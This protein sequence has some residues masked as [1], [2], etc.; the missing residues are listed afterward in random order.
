MK[1][2]ISCLIALALLSGCSKNDDDSPALSKGESKPAAESKTKS[3]PAAQAKS[4]SVWKSVRNADGETVLTLDVETQKRIGLQV[5]NPPVQTNLPEIR[6]SGRVLDPTPLAEG[7]AELE[8][9]RAALGASNLEFERLKALAAQNN[10]SARALQAAE[11][12][13]VRDRLAAGSARTK[14]TLAWGRELAQRDDLKALVESLVNGDAA[15]VRLDLAPG[16]V[17][18][19]APVEARLEWAGAAGRFA[20]AEFS[21]NAPGVDPQTQGA[22]FFFLLKTKPSGFAPGLAVLGHLSLAAESVKGVV[23]S[24]DSILRRDGA[25]WVFV[26]TAATE[27]TRRR[28]QLDWPVEAG[29]FEHAKLKPTDRVVTVGA[30]TLLSQEMGGS[31]FHGGEG[32]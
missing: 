18:A 21:G 11:A 17:L 24:S 8:T 27:F 23:V 22:G 16:E 13:A 1:S 4:E 14:L 15:L 28:I 7:V 12:L 2:I 29:W 5:D 20:R 26:Q 32:D 30:Q 3:E 19:A 6:C 9:A 25:A 10:A 31:A